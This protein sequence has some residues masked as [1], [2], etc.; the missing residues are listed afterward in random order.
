MHAFEKGQQ[1]TANVTAQGMTEGN[2]YTITDVISRGWGIVTYVLDDQ[3]AIG[4][5]HLLLRPAS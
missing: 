2:T 4:N 1:V 5:G 3:L